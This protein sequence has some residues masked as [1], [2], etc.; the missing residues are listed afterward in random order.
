[1]SQGNPDASPRRTPPLAGFCLAVAVV[2]LVFSGAGSCGMA[3]C[4]VAQESSLSM[5]GFPGSEDH[6]SP[7]Q[8]QDRATAERMV[9][10]P[11]ATIS[12]ALAL[13]GLASTLLALFL[14]AAS[15]V[16]IAGK[17]LAI[18]FLPVWSAFALAWAA[19][20]AVIYCVST[21]SAVSQLDAAV[22]TLGSTGKQIDGLD[23]LGAYAAWM[24]GIPSAVAHAV[25]PSVLL[26]RRPWKRAA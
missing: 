21:G 12:K 4:T 19:A 3:A 7:S 8:R 22:R 25:L 17:P 16:W 2:W 15:I 14:L 23:S 24:L 5:S 13:Q 26:W 11:L 1:M 6:L 10:A 18:R 9:T 20:M